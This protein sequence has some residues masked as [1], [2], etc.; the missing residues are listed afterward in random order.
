MKKEDNLPR[1]DGAFDTFQEVM[2]GAVTTNLVAW[3][4]PAPELAK[5]TEKQTIWAAK[6]LIAKD[7]K[8]CTSAQRQGKDTARKNYE[9]VLRPFIQ[10]W[11][12]LNEVMTDEDI[13]ECG[14]TPHDKIRTKV[15][16]PET[17][18]LVEIL[19]MPGNVAHVIFRQQLN[20]PGSSKRGKPEGVSKCEFYFII[21]T[22]P[23]SPKD[24]TMFMQSG[25]S[26]I[27]IPMDAGA[28][29]KKLW[30][31]ARWV[32]PAGE[33]GPWTTLDSFTIPY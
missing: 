33:G 5:L 11:I 26:P 6:W 7:K 8:N 17:I 14:L 20:E 19:N 32:N 21:D 28:G 9:A 27:K 24:C 4:I 2:V 25:R 23:K 31:Y 12:Y 13:E 10:K 15:P 30:F 22:E 1:P 3:E 16:V 18:P 29:G